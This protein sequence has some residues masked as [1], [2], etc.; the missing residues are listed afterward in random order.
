MDFSKAFDKVPHKRLIYKLNWYVIRGDSLEWI[1]DF[2]S[3]RSQRVVPDGATSDRAPVLSGVPQGTVRGP[4]LFLNY[5]NDLPDGVINST[6]RLF[7]DVLF[8]APSGAKKTQN[9]SS[10]TLIL[11]ALGK[12][13]GVC[14]LMQTNVL[15]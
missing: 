14:S 3:S 2:L 8:T 12:R 1:T 6:V 15:P 5:I 9:F 10:L 4:K 13:L 7:A 11:S